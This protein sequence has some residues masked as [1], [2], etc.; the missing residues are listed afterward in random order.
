LRHRWLG[1]GSLVAALAF[2]ALVVIGFRVSSTVPSIARS[3]LTIATVERGDF[4]R[5]VAADGVVVATLSPTLYS[6]TAG[7]VSLKVHAGDSVGE[8]QIVAV[9]D[10][11][12]LTAKLL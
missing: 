10:S 1:I 12:D 7:T 9:I 3:R 4:V 8:G 6:A 11:P 2:G 5:T